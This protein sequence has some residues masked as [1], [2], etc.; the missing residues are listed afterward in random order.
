VEDAVSES[1][2]FHLERFTQA[3]AGVYVQALAEIRQGRKRSH[4]MWFIFPQVEGLGL[5]RMARLYAISGAGEARAYLAHP[6][7]G[8]RLAEISRA[9]LAVEGRTAHEIFGWPDD[10]KLCSSATLFASVSEPD[11]LFH[12]IIDQYYAGRFDAKTL[13]LL[14]EIEHHQN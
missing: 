5:S 11:S 9:L 2:P 13:A 10:L 3:Q 1:D 8:S 6:L 14:R 7:L 4:W 12:Q